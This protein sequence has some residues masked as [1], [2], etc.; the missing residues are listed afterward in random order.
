MTL[1]S[2][3]EETLLSSD[4]GSSQLNFALADLRYEL[5]QTNC[6]ANRLV[7]VW[8]VFQ[9]LQVWLLI[10]LY[11]PPVSTVQD[12]PGS[13]CEEDWETPWKTDE[14]D[15]FQGEPQWRH[16]DGLSQSNSGRC[17]SFLR[18]CH[19]TKCA[20]LFFSFDLIV[21]ARMVLLKLFDVIFRRTE[22]SFVGMLLSSE[23]LI[24]DQLWWSHLSV[25][26]I[27]ICYL[28][29]IESATSVLHFCTHMFQGNRK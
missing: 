2:R 21:F 23:L 15:G 10:V 4:E 24:E 17:P 28:I 5:L 12:R 11:S 16:G 14:A 25:V 27:H 3:P 29:K 13:R 7:K 8:G 18:S 22:M 1:Y 6:D 9:V 26:R 20:Y 19:I